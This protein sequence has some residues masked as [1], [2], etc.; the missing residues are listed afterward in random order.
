MPVADSNVPTKTYVLPAKPYDASDRDQNRM[1]MI[2]DSNRALVVTVED[3]SR[4]PAAAM[5]DA[6]AD[7]TRG[8]A[9]KDWRV[10]LQGELPT[11]TVYGQGEQTGSTAVSARGAA[12]SAAST[13]RPMPA[14]AGS[15][16]RAAVADPEATPRPGISDRASAVRA[17]GDDGVRNFLG[18]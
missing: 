6:P 8:A 10:H 14:A 1:L 5:T 15:A 17:E 12:A 4:R 9:P 3:P 18:R 11:F 16:Y 2:P 13:A 7:K